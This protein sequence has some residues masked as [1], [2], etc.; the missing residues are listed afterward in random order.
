MLLFYHSNQGPLTT[1]NCIYSPLKLV[2]QWYI[3]SSQIGTLYSFPHLWWTGVF[4][5]PLSCCRCF[6]VKEYCHS[7]S[8]CKQH[9]YLMITY[10]CYALRGSIS[11]LLGSSVWNK[12]F[13]LY[14]GTVLCEIR[15]DKTDNVII[16]WC[17]HYLFGAI[18]YT[19]YYYF[20]AI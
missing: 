4:F 13:R 18:E 17:R 9:L 6:L 8:C 10:I 19:V 5:P 14:T 1:L 16:I 7:H 12:L 2:P 11:K 15:V 3:M 20:V